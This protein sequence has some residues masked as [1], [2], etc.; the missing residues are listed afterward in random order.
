MSET[1][2]NRPVS[3]TDPTGRTTTYQY[4]SFG[5]L[6]RTTLPEG[7]YVQYSYDA[8]GNVTETRRVSK[9]PGTPADIVTSAAYPA[10]CSN[11]VTCNLP[12]STTDARGFVT[13]YSYDPVHGGRPDGDCT[14]T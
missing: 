10:T 1:K 7:D 4:D 9:T 2:Y 3:D 5:R 14:C 11:P 8:R 13:D 6:T 12:T